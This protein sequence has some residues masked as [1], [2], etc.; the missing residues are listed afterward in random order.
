MQSVVR[1]CRLE[2]LTCTSVLLHARVGK[3]SCLPCSTTLKN[4]GIVFFLGRFLNRCSSW[5]VLMIIRVFGPAA[6]PN[7]RQ[8]LSKFTLF[9]QLLEEFLGMRSSLW[10]S[11]RSNMLADHVPVLAVE[12]KAFDELIVLV[13]SPFPFIYTFSIWAS[14]VIFFVLLIVV[15]SVLLL[16]LL[17][18]IRQLVV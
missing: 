10:A 8:E 6:R 12:L 13:F 2:F 7:T 16:W 4:V 15:S 9:L 5:L 1:N 11:T 17:I 3:R 18:L 14:C